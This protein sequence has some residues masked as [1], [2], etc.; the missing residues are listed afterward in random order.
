MFLFYLDAGL[1]GA[2]IVDA[3]R[4]VRTGS[5]ELRIG[6]AGDLRDQLLRQRPAE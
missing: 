5:R 1:P 2:R 6:Q 3:G 4:G